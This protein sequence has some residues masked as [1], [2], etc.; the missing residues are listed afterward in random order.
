VA[1]VVES[2]VQVF[3]E[4]YAMEGQ[5]LFESNPMVAFSC[6]PCTDLQFVVPGSHNL[7]TQ[8]EDFKAPNPA[9]FLLS[10]SSEGVPFL[11]LPPILPYGQNPDLGSLASEGIAHLPLILGSFPFHNFGAFPDASDS[12]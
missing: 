10:E 6:V 7:P 11:L 9:A 12:K 3:E 2:K 8:S 4:A 1:S 5:E